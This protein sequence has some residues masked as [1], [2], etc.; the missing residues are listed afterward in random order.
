LLLSIDPPSTTRSDDF[1]ITNLLFQIFAF[2]Q[3]DLP[4]KFLYSG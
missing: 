4:V 2:Y 1:A 3:C